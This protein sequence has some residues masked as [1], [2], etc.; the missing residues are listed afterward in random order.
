[1]ANMPFSGVPNEKLRNFRVGRFA[2]LFL[3]VV[4]GACRSIA[5]QVKATTAESASVAIIR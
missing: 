3:D 1:M 4:P 2:A 5:C